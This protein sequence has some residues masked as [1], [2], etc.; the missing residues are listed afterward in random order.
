MFWVKA[1][2]C[3]VQ[4]KQPVHS[5]LA[6]VKMCG[7][8]LERGASPLTEG[9]DAFAEVEGERS[10]HQALRSHRIAAG[11]GRSIDGGSAV[12]ESV[13]RVAI[14]KRVC[15]QELPKLRAEPTVPEIDGSLVA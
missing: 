6:N 15:R 7:R 9:E 10:R 11:I 3:S 5:G 8:R 12:G 14:L 1:A 2:G 13:V 4:R